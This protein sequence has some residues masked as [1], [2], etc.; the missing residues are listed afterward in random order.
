MNGRN[1]LS[2]ELAESN[3]KNAFICPNCPSKL[4]PVLPKQKRIKHF[5]HVTGKSHYEPETLEHLT[6]KTV[7]MELASKLGL[8]A[9]PEVKIGEH[10]TD[11]LVQGNQPLA[12]E[13]QCSKCHSTE[14]AER[15]RT[16]AD[17]G[18]ATFWILGA[19]FY[20]GRITKIERE[21]E[22]T[23]RVIYY[24]NNEFR[25]LRNE[26]YF[27]HDIIRF[28]A[29]CGVCFRDKKC[30]VTPQANATLNDIDKKIFDKHGK[31][32]GELMRNSKERTYQD[33]NIEWHIK[34]FNE[35]KLT[36][37]NPSLTFALESWERP[38]FTF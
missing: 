11:I 22:K 36:N 12:I 26:I 14:I 29:D 17:N 33:F 32:I 13:F 4:I 9:E 18:I 5:R 34:T 37:D 3:R 16:Y 19:N 20:R 24:V 1:F 15:N 38:F 25:Q 6:G 31:V 35:T 27:D 2:E 8:K 10:V 28:Y 30:T 21:I 7:L 23:Q